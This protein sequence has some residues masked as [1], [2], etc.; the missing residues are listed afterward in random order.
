M[1]RNESKWIEEELTISEF[2]ERF[3]G[4]SDYSSP[5]EYDIES[6]NIEILGKDLTTNKDVYRKI[7]KFIIKPPV[8]EYYTDGI[9][10]GTKAHRIIEN[11]V[12]ISLKDHP[13]FKQIEGDMYVSDFEVSDT[14]NYYANGRLNHN[15]VPGGK[16]LPFH[17]S[18]RVRLNSIEKIKNGEDVVG[19]ACKA[20][21]IKNRMG[22]PQR[23]ATFDIL[24][25]S[26]IQD[27]SSWFEFLKGEEK[28]G[29]T[30]PSTGE[31]LRSADFVNKINSDPMFKDEM[32]KLMCDRAIMKYRDPNSKIE[33]GLD[34]VAGD[35]A[36]PVTKEDKKL[37]LGE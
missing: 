1:K 27:I 11:N 9:L 15:T 29:F 8:N 13:D 21:V 31:K 10:N 24:F 5:E 35:E 26:G 25:D 18:V 34:R 33:E 3:L 12:E 22:P 17:S 6:M 4:I 16:A 37:L 19:V 30:V 23:T 28:G 36:E 14:H 32:Y 20:V 7:N 2:C